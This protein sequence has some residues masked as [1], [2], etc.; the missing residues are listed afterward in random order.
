MRAEV[1]LA[2]ALTFGGGEPPKAVQNCPCVTATTN[3]G[4]SSC[5]CPEVLAPQRP[6][7]QADRFIMKGTIAQPAGSLPVA[8]QAL[9][10][11]QVQGQSGAPIF[12]SVRST[13]LTGITSGCA[14]GSCQ[15][16]TQ[17]GGLFRR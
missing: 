1:A 12:T 14:N 10:F 9:G 8:V 17:R 6:F 15:S 4:C 2:L 16:A 5:Q 11:R 7:G 13:G 3:C